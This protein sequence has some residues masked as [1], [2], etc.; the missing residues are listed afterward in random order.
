MDETWLDDVIAPSLLQG[1]DVNMPD[2]GQASQ[3]YESERCIVSGM[4]NL[5]DMPVTRS[6]HGGKRKVAASGPGSR[7]GSPKSANVVE[8]VYISL[9]LRRR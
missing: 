9:Q 7:Y 3:S 1:I 4:T 6:S 2:I 8:K 5:L